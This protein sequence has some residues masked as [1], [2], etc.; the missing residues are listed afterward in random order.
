MIDFAPH[1]INY[2]L[3]DLI[4]EQYTTADLAYSLSYKLIKLFEV[5]SQIFYKPAK[6]DLIPLLSESLS[7]FVKSLP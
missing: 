1:L 5:H 6:V 7:I 4:K 2:L 3:N